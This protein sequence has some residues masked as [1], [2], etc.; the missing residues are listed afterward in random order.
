MPKE[1]KKPKN[2]SF[3]TNE[4]AVPQF[5]GDRGRLI[6][7]VQ[8]VTISDKSMPP[9]FSDP[10]LESGVCNPHEPLSP[11]EP[12]QCA[13]YKSC[14]VAKMIASGISIR[15]TDA[16]SMEYDEILAG[17]DIL[18]DKEAEQYLTNE[19][20]G[21]DRYHLRAH[22]VGISL[23]RSINSYRKNSMRR[24]IFDILSENWTTLI[25]LKAQIKA[26]KNDVENIDVVLSQVTT[27]TAQ[28]ERGYRVMESFGRYK[29]F[30]R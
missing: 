7:E 23:R 19:N 8:G 11:A 27:L 12:C 22:A 17:A 10:N 5:E 16:R 20:E 30:K 28:E 6:E 2:S 26:A 14:L 13:L 1:I 18:F 29:I 4:R 15:S 24:L 21:V 25:D 3:V 9:C